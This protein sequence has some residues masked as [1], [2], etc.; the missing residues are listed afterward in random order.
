MWCWGWVPSAGIIPPMSIRRFAPAFFCLLAFVL[1]VP[2]LGARSLWG[3][4]AFSVWA[5]RQSVF[6]LLRGIDAQPPLYHLALKLGRAGFGESVFALRFVSV[7]C[8]VLITPLVWRTARSLAGT[9]AANLAALATSAAAIVTYYQQEA[10]MY[11]LAAAF[12]CAA[13]AL[14]ARGLERGEL[15]AREWAALV[16]VSLGALFG[17][18]FTLPI[19]AVNAVA[20]GM[21]ALRRKEI[22]NIGNIGNKEGGPAKKF[23]SL[24][25][26]AYSL[27][28]WLLAH[29]AIAVGFGA[30]F[31][32]LQWRVLTRASP[33]RAAGLP[34]PGEIIDNVQRGV[35]GLIFGLK[36]EPWHAP[37][38]LIL[39]AL[40]LF[41]VRFARKKTALVWVLASC[42]FV[43][44]TASHSGIV[45]DFHPRYL[46]FAFAPLAI[47]AG[48]WCADSPRGLR[49][50]APV[51]LVLAVA[52]VGQ[53]AFFDSSWKKSR[54]DELMHL[55]R[56]RARPGDVAVLLN[57]DQFPLVDYYGPAGASTWILDNGLWGAAKEPEQLAQFDKFAGAAPRVWLVKYGWA[58]TPG[59]RSAIEQ[60]TAA[61]GVRLYEGEFGDAVLTLY[62]R[63]DAAGAPPLQP[64]GV[65]FGDAIV[66]ESSRVRGAQ[67][68]PGDAIPL[69]LIWRAAA[70]P[71]ADYTVFV[72]LRRSDDGMQIAANDSPPLNGAAPTSS[73]S[74]GQIFTDTRGVMAPADA[75][76]GKYVLVIGLYRYPSFERLPVDGGVET[77]YVLREVEIVK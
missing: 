57:S 74:T 60:R 35:A 12:A 20:L 67:F 7:L 16:V 33:A 5:S 3:D 10:R 21:S 66:L 4:E 48:E 11:A 45:P 76:P 55:L 6:D 38:A 44:A 2:L 27:F 39:F 8:G 64:A 36:T 46:L 18:F 43:F 22:G 31:F 1:A 17:H 62:E 50:W 52:V 9:G 53:S 63:A 34:P 61:N 25:L 73:W 32:G 29:I 41:G 49:R 69:D 23:P 58:S 42:A 26:V 19:L 24:S 51:L 47:A 71:A 40:A 75:A 56:E 70:K 13:M 59:L 68:A 15:R 37:V 65:R 77:E 72:H 30:W 14:T 28:P 54:Y